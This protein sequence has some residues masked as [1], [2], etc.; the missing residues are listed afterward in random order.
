[1]RAG[2]LL[3]IAFGI[4]IAGVTFLILRVDAPNSGLRLLVFLLV[5]LGLFF[6]YR[7]WR[8]A[9]VSFWQFI[10]AL[11]GLGNREVAGNLALGRA[12]LLPFFVA[13]VI[14]AIDFFLFVRPI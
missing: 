11:F 9:N 10:L 4:L 2:G 14:L 6:L 7:A 12:M 5:G 8:T 1:M 3:S 13:G